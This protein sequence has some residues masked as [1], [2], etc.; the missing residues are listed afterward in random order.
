MNGE[1]IY[2][3][4]LSQEELIWYAEWMERTDEGAFNEVIVNALG[5][6]EAAG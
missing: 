5:T 6:L 1:Q 4:L 2:L 3:F